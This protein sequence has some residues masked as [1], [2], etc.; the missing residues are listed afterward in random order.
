MAVWSI[1]SRMSLALGAVLTVASM[2]VNTVQAAGP[3]GPAQ[4]IKGDRALGTILVDQKGWTLYGFLTDNNGPSTCYGVCE[5]FWPP[6]LTS[7][8]PVAGSGVN[9]GLLGTT[10]RTDG[11]TQVTY[12]GWPLYYFSRD[13]GPG[14]MRGQW[15][16]NTW[17]AFNT[18]GTF[19]AK[20]VTY[21]GTASSPIGNVLVGP[22]R[23][24]LYELDAD[25]NGMSTCNGQCAVFWPPLLTDV[26][27][28]ANTGLNASLFG[29]ITR[30]DGKLQ[31]TYN[32][33]P[34]YYWHKDSAP[35]QWNGQ[36]IGNVWWMVSPAGARLATK[37]PANATLSSSSTIYGP[38]LA[39]TNG[40][41]VYMFAKDANGQSA[42]YNSCAKIWPPVLSD[43]PV[44]VGT[45]ADAKLI[46]TMKRTDGT[47]QVTYNGMPL[48]Y[49]SGDTAAGQLSGQN[50]FSVWFV[51]RPSGKVLKPGD[52]Q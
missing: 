40:R 38:I 33:M 3:T 42:C 44:I 8:L 18:D 11:T 34:L 14:D 48:Y 19:N 27:P 15:V 37:L 49:F 23:H 26:Q 4:V 36:G 2:S 29:T 35:G 45:G 30:N 46:G 47:T 21:V 41:T 1:K 12:N 10:M 13:T 7:G 24:T 32:G 52:Q 43:V 50:T 20:V 17:F 22:N 25:K 28:Q 16:L 39:G 51:L 6:L 31:V 9:Q 5:T